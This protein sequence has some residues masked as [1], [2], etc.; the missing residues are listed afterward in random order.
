MLVLEGWE[1]LLQKKEEKPNIYQRLAAI[2][3]ENQQDL[4]KYSIGK[5]I[6]GEKVDTGDLIVNKT[7]IGDE[8][9]N[10]IDDQI[11]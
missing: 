9:L 4:L 5:L 8:Q 11:K 1:I 2:S 10:K 6:K 3:P 7:R